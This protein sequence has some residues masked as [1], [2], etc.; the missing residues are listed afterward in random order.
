[1]YSELHSALKRKRTFLERKG[2]RTFRAALA[3]FKATSHMLEAFERV[4]KRASRKKLRVIDG[5][6]KPE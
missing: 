4:Q 1:M 5:G 3:S 6:L 2:G